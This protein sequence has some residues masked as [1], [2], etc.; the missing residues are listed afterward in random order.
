LQVAR[1]SFALWSHHISLIFFIAN[2]ILNLPIFN[3]MIYLLMGKKD[4]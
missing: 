4:M 1:H 2:L 3:I